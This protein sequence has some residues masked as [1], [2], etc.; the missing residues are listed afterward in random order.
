MCRTHKPQSRVE[1]VRVRK[2]LRFGLNLVVRLVTVDFF[3]SINSA[4]SFFH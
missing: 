3:F 2:R 1:L 4:H